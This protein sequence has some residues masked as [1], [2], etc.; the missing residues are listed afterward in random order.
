MMMNAESI[1]NDDKHTESITNDENA[2]F[3]TNDKHTESITNDENAK[4]ITN[5][6]NAKFITNDEN[7]KFITN[8]DIYAMIIFKHNVIAYLFSYVL[9]YI[10]IFYEMGSIVSAP[11]KAINSATGNLARAVDSYSYNKYAAQH[12]A[13]ALSDIYEQN[14]YANVMMNQ[15]NA[16]VEKMAI[17]KDSDVDQINALSHFNDS[18]ND[19]SKTNINT[20]AKVKMRE[21]DNETKVRLEEEKTIQNKH[22]VIA[23]TVQNVHSRTMDTL[24]NTVNQVTD[25][26]KHTVTSTENVLH[27]GLDSTEN[28]LHHG[29]DTVEN[30]SI[31]A[32]DAVE[33]IGI[34]ALDTVETVGVKALDT[35]ENIITDPNISAGI[36]ECIA[37]FDINQAINSASKKGMKGGMNEES[38][39]IPDEEYNSIIN[40]TQKHV[41]K[42]LQRDGL[43]SVL[44]RLPDKMVEY[45]FN[46][47]VVPDYLQADW[48]AFRNSYLELINLPNMIEDPKE[49]EIFRNALVQSMQVPGG[50]QKFIKEVQKKKLKQKGGN[51]SHI[52]SIFYLIM[53][54]IT[55]ITIVIVI[56]ISTKQITTINHILHQSS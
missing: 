46:N 25:T 5:D 18:D 43:I 47:I 8:D 51:S 35:A 44:S 37:K 28:V 4:F 21:S 9:V 45:V 38:D 16:T 32:I 52:T 6:E 19:V 48:N 24:D 17:L 1:T 42:A 30:V 40:D 20:S 26:V 54:A 29:L 23:E 50:L 34:K 22:K 39:S 49:K 14:A 15:Q 31:R 55:I 36:G 27:H 7:A 12:E 56:V 2:K 3:I 11:F 33:H 13:K 10:F 53:I 41:E